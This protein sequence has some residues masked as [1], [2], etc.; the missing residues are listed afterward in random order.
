MKNLE[1]KHIAPYLPYGL[2][3]ADFLVKQYG[4]TKPL[5]SDVESY[6]IRKFVDD[7]TNSKIILKPL[8]DLEKCKDGIIKSLLPNDPKDYLNK[9]DNVIKNGIKNDTDFGL[10]NW[11]YE[12][13]FD[14]YNLIPNG[15]AHDI[16]S[17]IEFKPVEL[18]RY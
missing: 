12:N 15:L 3:A 4:L 17:L 11:M 16:N 5:I 2:K 6:N 14:V 18:I 13:H 1:L 8:S 9:I 7:G 10:V